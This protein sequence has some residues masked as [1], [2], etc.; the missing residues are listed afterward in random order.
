MK[1]TF[2]RPDDDDDGRRP[3]DTIRR[4]LADINRPAISALNNM[5]RFDNVVPKSVLA[6]IVSRTYSQLESKQWFANVLPTTARVD[7]LADVYK[8]MDMQGILSGLRPTID[9]QA[10]INAARPKI[11][12]S[13]LADIAKVNF[14]QQ[15]WLQ[16]IYTGI[17]RPNFNR[18]TQDP[19]WTRMSQAIAQT[20][21][22]LVDAMSEEAIEAV[23]EE[24]LGKADFE[25][26][27]DATGNTDLDSV[28]EINDP[29]LEAIL[30]RGA[31]WVE[32]QYPEF[33][34]RTTALLNMAAV[35][36]THTLVATLIPGLLVLAFGA[37]GIVMATVLNGSAHFYTEYR[38]G[39][40]S[41]PQAMATDFACP[42]CKALPGMQCIT[43]RGENIG[44]RTS[45]HSD[46]LR[47]SQGQ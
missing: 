44:N 35:S 15:E 42:Y 45:M 2:K 8:Q 9:T 10:W 4:I 22:A 36:V 3:D 7:F 25:D 43:V 34:D 14:D 1:T 16:R 26:L 39:K 28:G 37:E 41:Q 31:H 33:A 40:M 24:T 19:S 32:N 21:V 29:I 38:K 20:G 23:L 13:A 27:D 30:R 6:D 11:H 5:T 18:I 17:D 46:R 47:L 12:F